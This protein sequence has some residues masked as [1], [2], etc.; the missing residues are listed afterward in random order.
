MCIYYRDINADLHWVHSDPRHTHCT[1]VPDN[2][3]SYRRVIESEEWLKY[4]NF[5]KNLILLGDENQQTTSCT[6]DWGDEMENRC[7][8]WFYCYQR[9]QIT[10]CCFVYSKIANF[11]PKIEFVLFC[12]H[13]KRQKIKLE[14][15]N[16][17]PAQYV[18]LW[19]PLYK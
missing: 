1:K 11:T 3:R 15:K 19:G 4:D 13:L 17:D 5:F 9:E 14:K 8:G 6:V 7:T 18:F 2:Y 10:S 12:S 16:C